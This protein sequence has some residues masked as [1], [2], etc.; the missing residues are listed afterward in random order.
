MRAYGE[1]AD[2]VAPVTGAVPSDSFENVEVTAAGQQSMDINDN[3]RAG[4]HVAIVGRSARV[5]RAWLGW[6]LGWYRPANGRI[7]VDGQD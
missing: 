7:L 3:L 6:L 5:N 1:N 2:I 4:E